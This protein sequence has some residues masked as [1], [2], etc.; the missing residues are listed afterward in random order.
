MCF[1]NNIDEIRG[2]KL[3]FTST[4]THISKKNI[5]ELIRYFNKSHLKKNENITE[6]YTNT[7][8]DRKMEIFL[9]ISKIQK[10]FQ[11]TTKWKKNEMMIRIKVLCQCSTIFY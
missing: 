2:D 3:I 4:E 11:Q 10:L 6:I 5:Q 8:V 7:F 1:Y 9:F